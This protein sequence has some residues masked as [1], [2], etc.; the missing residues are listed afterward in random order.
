MREP[1]REQRFGFDEFHVLTEAAGTGNRPTAAN[2]RRRVRGPDR[3]DA[4]AG[5][6][7][8]ILMAGHGSQQPV[9]P[10]D[11]DPE[12]FEPDG[13]DEIFLP[14]DVTPAHDSSPIENSITDNQIRGWLTALRQKGTTIAIVVDACHSGGMVRG[15]DE[16]EKTREV[17]AAEVL[18]SVAAIE[19]A[20][21]RRGQTAGSRSQDAAD[22][23]SFKTSAPTLPCS[24]WPSTPPRQPNR[25][26]NENFRPV[27]PMPS[28]TAC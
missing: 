16:E 22:A 6:Q 1:A 12:N 25:P 23:G 26:L 19:A 4:E 27:R 21:K 24:S 7:I 9:D 2:I 11:H 13:L 15:N 10:E 5:D 17:P 14:A 18:S 8:F 3:T 28:P 20:E